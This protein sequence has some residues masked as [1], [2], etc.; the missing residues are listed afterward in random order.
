MRRAPLAP[1]ED[2]QEETD[3]GN[4]EQF[5]PEED[6]QFKHPPLPGHQDHHCTDKLWLFLFIVVVCGFVFSCVYAVRFGHLSKLYQGYDLAGRLC[7]FDEGVEDQ[8][9]VYWC[10]SNDDLDAEIE[11][12]T[13]TCVAECPGP[14]GRIPRI[15]V[16]NWLQKE[17]NNITTLID[18]T[19]YSHPQSQGTRQVGHYC[20][21]IHQPDAM[22]KIL[23][24]TPK[25]QNGS[26]G[27]ALQ[28]KM[29][30]IA[31][32]V[33]AAENALLFSG[34]LSVVVGYCYLLFLSRFAKLLAYVCEFIV[35]GGTLGFGL[36]QTHYAWYHNNGGDKLVA[37]SEGIILC[38][39]GIMLLL[40]VCCMNQGLDMAVGVAQAATECMWAEPA[41]LLD[42]VIQLSGKAVALKLGGVTFVRL[43]CASDVEHHEGHGAFMREFHPTSLEWF[44]LVCYGIA[45]LWILEYG[46]ALSSYA[47]SYTTQAWYFTPFVNGEKCSK[48]AH[49]RRGRRCAIF[50]GYRNGI[51]FH[52]GTL[53]FGAVLLGCLRAVR[54]LLKVLAMAAED[55]G[56]IGRIVDLCFGCFIDCYRDHIE[57]LDR[58]AYMDVAI[59]SDNFFPAAKRA[60]DLIN[61]EVPAVAALNGTQLIFLVTGTGVI[62]VTCAFVTLE[63]LNAHPDFY[64][65]TSG[66]YVGNPRSVT[67]IG[68][69]LGAIIGASFMNIFDTVGDTILY[70]FAS[71]QRRRSMINHEKYGDGADVEDPG[72]FGWLMGTEPQPVEEEGMG[73]AP[74]GLIALIDRHG[75]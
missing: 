61:N 44:L 12:T 60:V 75:R 70:C 28:S 6:S 17:G 48:I 55:T 1:D 59:T 56:P 24:G 67:V 46:H 30:R 37:L 8:Y 41:M 45:F 14:E 19:N 73:Y 7:G 18:L 66:H 35:V 31:H 33:R 22:A 36:Y 40:L 32:D 25:S 52:S 2:Q 29:I 62:S 42:P 43:L 65:H 71:E 47:L 16:I 13:P 3:P 4:D 26:F 11:L 58:S 34:I 69:L 23:G 10:P 64:E 68:G 50:H 53:A 27:V 38:A 51:F 63:V 74:D 72:F 15:C 21:P 39:F 20:L 5:D 9:L 54:V 49:S 57:M